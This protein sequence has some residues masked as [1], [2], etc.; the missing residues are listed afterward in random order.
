MPNKASKLFS[1]YFVFS[2]LIGFFNCIAYFSRSSIPPSVYFGF[3]TKEITLICGIFLLTFFPLAFIS[4]HNPK[5]CSWFNLALCQIEGLRR[6][7]LLFGLEVINWILFYSFHIYGSLRLLIFW[8]IVTICLMIIKIVFS[9]IGDPQYLV[10]GF[11][12]FGIESIAIYEVQNFLFP[13]EAY[14]IWVLSGLIVYIF[15][16]WF[17]IKNNY[18]TNIFMA[19]DQG[20]PRFRDTLLIIIEPVIISV[21]LTFLSQGMVVFYLP[22]LWIICIV[23]TCVTAF[24]NYL[25][26]FI[27]NARNF[28]LGANNKTWAFFIIFTVVI[29]SV[30]FFSQKTYDPIN[31]LF[32]GVAATRGIWFTIPV[33]KSE[34]FPF[35][36]ARLEDSISDDLGKPFFAALGQTVGLVKN[37]KYPGPDTSVTLPSPDRN[38]AIQ[39]KYNNAVYSMCENWIETLPGFFWRI[40]LVGIF[41]LSLVFGIAVAKDPVDFGLISILML[42]GWFKWP[43]SD[44]IRVGDVVVL[45]A[46][47]AFIG[48]ILPLMRRNKYSYLVFWGLFT[49]LIF[50]LVSFVRQ[51]CGIALLV[52][53]FVVL[54]FAGFQ[55]KNML[56]ALIT[57]A[58]LLVGSSLIPAATNGLFL[59][60]D[61]KL[62][63]SAPG[64][65]P[66]VH[67]SGLA[68]LG[69]I[70]GSWYDY[71]SSYEYKNSLDIAF[72][73]AIVWI[74]VYNENPMIS[75]SQNSI[76]MLMKTGEGLFI[77][78]VINHPL[79]F[80]SITL[81]KAYS[82]FILM[83]RVPIDWISIF[84][85]FVFILGLR[86]GIFRRQLFQR[87][88]PVKRALEIT[89]IYSILIIVAA[90][91]AIITD[92]N[93][94]EST[95]PPAAVMFF[96]FVFATYMLI[97]FLYIKGRIGRNAKM[98]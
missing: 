3:S 57:S 82:T 40:G 26:V 37:C 61:I 55:Q 18:I 79:E 52:T 49:G 96:M 6:L 65:S 76:E 16:E 20:N 92:P 45:I 8:G 64:I 87:V 81:Q 2:G 93:Y 74:N 59:Y 73:D 48:I 34:L 13:L 89:I 7:L 9:T 66:R 22:I 11:F 23:H 25:I 84:L 85:L 35:G 47:T 17:L 19:L 69:G 24:A 70:G 95:Y 38:K 33:E 5:I 72:R 50:G 21:L 60:R 75:F 83:L 63:I 90:L 53:S 36:Y 44:S 46:G 42:F 80:M 4:W 41:L 14:W 98:D 1:L 10:I 88:F 30:A 31:P 56:L 78:Y 94:G 68:L 43:I 15:S 39:P 28:Q 97:N 91:P 86:Y 12:V 71:P 77:R 54:I 51:P 67:G 62:Q 27:R 58:A 32:E 29:Y